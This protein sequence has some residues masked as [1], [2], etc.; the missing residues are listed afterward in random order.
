M[1][2]I[3]TGARVSGTLA[4]WVDGKRRGRRCFGSQKNAGT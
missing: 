4:G 1:G 2:D 3:A